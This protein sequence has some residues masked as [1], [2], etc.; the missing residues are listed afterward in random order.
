VEIAILKVCHHPKIV[1]YI[2]SWQKG[3]ELFI[4]MELCDGASIDRL[5]ETVGRGLNET[6]LMTITR[7]SLLGLEYLH[8]AHTLHR[9]IK[10]A[11]L[12]VN[13]R[14]ECKLVDF[15][16]CVISEPGQKRMTFIGSP[17]WMAPEVID[18][19]TLP[20]PYGP[21]CDVWSLGVTLLEM[22]DNCVPLSELQP[23]VALRQIPSRDPPDLKDPSAWSQD[24]K[25]FLLKCLQKDP[26]DRYDTTQLQQMNWLVSKPIGP[27]CL[28]ELVKS[29]LIAANGEAP[30]MP[31]VPSTP[32]GDVETTEAAPATPSAAA[33]V[34]PPS[35]AL[36]PR[37]PPEDPK[38]LSAEIEART[39]IDES[40]KQLLLANLNE[41][42]KKNRPSSLR[43]SI[44]EQDKFVAQVKNAEAVK[45]QLK[46][47]KKAQQKQEAATKSKQKAQAGEMDKL[48]K[49]KNG[50]IDKAKASEAGALK[51]LNSKSSADMDKL[52]KA[53]GAA[54]KNMDKTVGVEQKDME[55][56]FGAQKSSM[57]KMVK[58]NQSKRTKGTYANNKKGQL[59]NK[60]TKKAVAALHKEQDKEWA[61]L[62]DANMTK[63]TNMLQ[64]HQVDLDL[65]LGDFHTVR[66][67]N[68]E[69]GWKHLVHL[70][71]VQWVQRRGLVQLEGLMKEQTI[72][73]EYH[74]KEQEL[75]LEHLKSLHALRLEQTEAGNKL[76]L[77]NHKVSAEKEFKRLMRVHKKKAAE[78]LKKWK[79]NVAGTMK[80]GKAEVKQKTQVE[81]EKMQV[82][83]RGAEEKYEASVKETMEKD[84]KALMEY[85]ADSEARLKEFQSREMGKMVKESE[86]KNEEVLEAQATARALLR[87]KVTVEALTL[88]FTHTKAELEVMKQ[89]QSDTILRQANM[90][91]ERNAARV[92]A[93]LPAGDADEAWQQQ[94]I[95]KH[96]AD[97][98][99]LLVDQKAQFV[100]VYGNS[101]E[102]ADTIWSHRN[103]E[104]MFY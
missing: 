91:N 93:G 20:S 64:A 86:K 81:Q 14:G 30:E 85:Q 59:K 80:G 103:S 96:N 37:A 49:A 74:K 100:E 89:M 40:E 36:S 76:E 35:G 79:K 42:Q 22:A 71:E 52:R 98:E 99:A 50:A 101:D 32:G 90:R 88:L 102:L 10:S 94:M 18:N 55:K 1:E 17:Y 31:E 63:L 72:E 57:A 87:K 19:R 47:A 21:K 45:E 9:D 66:G 61:G 95:D 34:P 65:T 11:N 28:Q 43:R 29:Y 8:K 73:L 82:Q 38:M 97:Q 24:F 77:E 15:G 39:D 4:A 54:A 25:D 69:T 44:R 7:D 78:D 5:Q 2:G 92:Q 26:D 3:T 104:G 33:V 68:S 46:Q 56:R 67:K 6:E 12:L 53:E 58:D 51:G 60:N 70:R 13:T 23:M 83:Q 84:E 41:S 16:V 48:T 62:Q 75:Q 27:K